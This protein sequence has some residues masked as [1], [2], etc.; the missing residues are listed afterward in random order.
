MALA[1]PSFAATGPVGISVLTVA[2]LGGVLSLGFEM[3]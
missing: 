3:K 1:I 2:I